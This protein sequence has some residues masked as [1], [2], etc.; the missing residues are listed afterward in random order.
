MNNAWMNTPL[1]EIE[2]REAH[3]AGYRLV[4]RVVAKSIRWA[5]FWVDEPGLWQ[6]FQEQFN[7]ESDADAI[8]AVLNSI[9]DS[10]ASKI[11][12]LRTENQALRDENMLLSK[13]LVRLQDELNSS[14]KNSAEKT[15]KPVN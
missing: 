2:R 10:I 13:S 11:E 12:V 5:R 6:F 9:L 7:D 8:A 15:G 4:I 3:Q 1:N 14:R